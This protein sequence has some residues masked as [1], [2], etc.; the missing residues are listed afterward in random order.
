MSSEWIESV[1]IKYF[2]EGGQKFTKFNP[3]RG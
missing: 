3:L 1:L 2:A